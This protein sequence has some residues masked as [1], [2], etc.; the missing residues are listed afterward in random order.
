MVWEREECAQG[1]S[2]PPQFNKHLL[3]SCSELSTQIKMAKGYSLSSLARPTGLP[4]L[5]L[6][7]SSSAFLSLV[8]HTHPHFQHPEL[9]TVSSASCDIQCL[10][11]P[12]PAIPPLPTIPS[13]FDLGNSYSSFSAQIKHFEKSSPERCYP[14]VGLVLPTRLW[15]SPDEK[16]I[17]QNINISGE[18]QQDKNNTTL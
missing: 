15:C 5:A 16:A 9:L 8:L 7:D 10:P 1:K 17:S 18:L 6:S 3:A 11:L 2:S 12:S 14:V 4:H 13:L